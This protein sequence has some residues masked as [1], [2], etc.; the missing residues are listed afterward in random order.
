M[1]QITGILISAVLA[2]SVLMMGM[3]VDVVRCAHSGT[4]RVVLASDR[5]ASGNTCANAASGCM[6]INHFQLSPTCETQPAGID[7]SAA[8]TSTLGLGNILELWML[9]TTVNEP[10][11][12]TA[13]IKPPPRQY[14]NFIG[15]LLI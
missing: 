13:A 1:R 14:L 4:V 15:V 7:L 9:P 6:E 11:E 10:P 3:G 2:V 12:T 8:P 5:T